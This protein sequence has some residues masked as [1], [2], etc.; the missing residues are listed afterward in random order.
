MKLDEKIEYNELKKK[1]LQ[2]SGK[3]IKVLKK[4]K[5]YYS[6]NG[7]ILEHFS[8][9]KNYAILLRSCTELDEDI[10][11]DF[12]LILL[13]DLKNIKRVNGNVVRKINPRT[14]ST[15]Q[16]IMIF[17]KAKEFI[18]SGELSNE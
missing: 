17:Y 18:D 3:D 7:D 1:F 14:V 8:S 13:K 5:F 11:I 10:K 6:N 15:T 2:E 9:Y 4:Q 16:K 12:V